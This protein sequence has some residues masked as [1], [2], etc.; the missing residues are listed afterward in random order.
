MTRS[1]SDLNLSSSGDFGVSAY[2]GSAITALALVVLFAF[3]GTASAVNLL[4]NG[5]FEDGLSIGGNGYESLPPTSTT[6]TAWTVV[7]APAGGVNIVDGR[8]WD[9]P[10]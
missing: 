3:S 1:H 4:T 2:R 9:A 10:T 6:L 5:S 7:S 8:I